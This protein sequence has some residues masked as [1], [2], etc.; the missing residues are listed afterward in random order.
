ML[1]GPLASERIER[2]DPN[3]GVKVIQITSYPT[4]SQ[5]LSYGW[6][7]VTPDNERVIITCQ[8]GAGRRAPWDVFRSD[9]DGFNLYQL[10]ERRAEAGNL[11][12]VLSLDGRTVY[13]AWGGDKVVAAVDVE[14]GRSEDLLSIEPYCPSGE[15]VHA[16]LSLAGNDEW[17]FVSMRTKLYARVRLVRLDL[18]SGKVKEFGEDMMHYGYNF[19]RGRLMILR[20]IRKDGVVTLP[21]GRRTMGNL[22]EAQQ[23]I[24]STDIDGND[25]VYGGTTHDYGHSTM[26]GRTGLIQGTG[27]PPDRCIIVQEPGGE[28]RKIVQGPYFW[29]SGPSFDG[30]WIIS[31]TSWPNEGL[32]LVHV[33]SRCY[34]TLCQDRAEQGHAGAH[35]HPALSQDGRVAVFDSDMTGVRQVYIAHI[36]EEFRE[37]IKEGVLDN[38]NDKWMQ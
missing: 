22:R 37:S 11:S 1:R 31:D 32:K 23:T 26:L 2:T 8:R 7:S 38:P 28:L 33:P 21:D 34:R 20:D 30:E 4:P 25:P 5:H 27:L 35:A 16:G 18:S 10:I 29:H 19:A 12:A 6:P 15:D 9:S 14:T 36:T 24:W 3:T 17:L 13:A